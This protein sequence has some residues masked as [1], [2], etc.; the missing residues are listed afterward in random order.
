MQDEQDDIQSTSYFIYL[1]KRD[2]YKGIKVL[3]GSNIIEIIS[4]MYC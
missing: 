2:L 3:T 4:V 1:L